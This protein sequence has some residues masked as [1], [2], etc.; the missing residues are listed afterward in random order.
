MLDLRAR[1]IKAPVFYY[2]YLVFFILWKFHMFMPQ[3]KTSVLWLVMVVHALV[4]APGRQRQVHSCEFWASLV[5]KVSSTSAK[6]TWWDLV[7]KTKQQQNQHHKLTSVYKSCLSGPNT[8][9]SG[10]SINTCWKENT[11]KKKDWQ[12]LWL[13]GSC[14][15]FGPRRVCLWSPRDFIVTAPKVGSGWT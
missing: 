10:H 11:E 2:F 8:V 12:Q 5:Y 9:H 4:P 7:P 15:N 14:L 1:R 6:A 13:R 3:S